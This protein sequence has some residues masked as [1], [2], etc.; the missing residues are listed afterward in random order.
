VFNVHE[1]T[2]IN[3]ENKAVTYL[4]LIRIEYL[5]LSLLCICG[6]IG[7]CGWTRD[8][9]LQDVNLARVCRKQL[10]EVYF[11]RVVRGS[12]SSPRAKGEGQQCEQERYECAQTRERRI[13]KRE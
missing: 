12:H 1:T 11:S 3:R 8:T 6:I 10:F 9:L 4:I 2:V 13:E 5:F 7:E